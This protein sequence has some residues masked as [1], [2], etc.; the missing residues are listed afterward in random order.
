MSMTHIPVLLHEV[1]RTLQP[2][3]GETFVDGTLGSGGHAE[4]I[5]NALG[6]RG[7]FIGIDA[8]A[9]PAG[10]TDCVEGYIIIECDNSCGSL[11]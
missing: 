8:D 6:E 7:M 3:E 11:L 9:Q 2:K 10:I 4:V 1:V 5:L